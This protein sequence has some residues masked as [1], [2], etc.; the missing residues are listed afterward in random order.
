MYSLSIVARIGIVLSVPAATIASAQT[1][2]TAAFITTV[3]ADTIS[4]EQYGRDGN[5]IRGVWASRSASSTQ[6]YYYQIMLGADGGATRYSVLARPAGSTVP[7][8]RLPSLTIQYG[9]DTAVFSM[10]GDVVMTKRVAM[11]GAYPRLGTSVVGIELALVRLRSASIDASTIVLNSPLGPS[12]DPFRLPVLFVRPDSVRMTSDLSARLDADGRIVRLHD[13]TRETRR[14]SPA[15][16]GEI[17]D[18]WSSD[19]STRPRV[20]RTK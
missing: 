8:S 7:A 20:P 4:V 5:T 17:I 19:E 9:R 11:S 10:Q 13:A 12:F 14:V 2:P 18:K 3:G 1:P 16:A 6:L 15:D